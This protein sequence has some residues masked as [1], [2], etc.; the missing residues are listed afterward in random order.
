VVLLFLNFGL[1]LES[2]HEL[3]LQLVIVFPCWSY[4]HDLLLQHIF[5]DVLNISL[6]FKI[7]RL[8]KL[9]ILWVDHVIVV[10]IFV[11]IYV[12]LLIVALLV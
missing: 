3:L 2:L 5:G 12:L 8:L 11:V 7:K 1:V 4:C 9:N 10:S 6:S